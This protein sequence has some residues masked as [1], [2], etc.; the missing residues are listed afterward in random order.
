MIVSLGIPNICL[1]QEDI[2]I[3]KIST[4]DDLGKVSVKLNWK[5]IE[6]ASSYFVTISQNNDFHD[7]RV[8]KTEK[9]KFF[10]MVYPNKKYFWK[11]TA[12]DKNEQALQEQKMF[13]FMAAYDGPP[14]D[15]SLASAIDSNSIASQ[16]SCAKERN[17]DTVTQMQ[18]P[19]PYEP[20]TNPYKM[21][22][23]T[24]AGYLNF[25]QSH[26]VLSNVDS[27]GS[28]F[29]SIGVNVQ[30]RNYWDQ[31]YA[32]LFFQQII[33]NFENSQASITLVNDSFQWMRFGASLYH[34]SALWSQ[35]ER[36]WELNPYISL[37]QNKSPY[38]SGLSPTSVAVNDMSLLSAIIGFR[39]STNRSDSPWAYILDMNYGQVLSSSSSTLTVNDLSGTQIEVQ[40]GTEYTTRNQFFFGG[41]LKGSQRNIDEQITSSGNQISNGERTINY[42]SIEALAG[43]YF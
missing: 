6:G 14:I 5:K 43:F 25:Q 12:L 38:M 32:K 4:A 33:G 9:R 7:G 8:F 29:P 31:L 19:T 39:L 40:L 36:N 17:P 28:L 10:T 18:A 3:F 37:E 20:S 22:L 15:R 30:T 1:G 42:Y 26:S 16:D 11:V 2:K 34:R 21:W 23:S 41:F 35:W 27:S 24:E 13:V